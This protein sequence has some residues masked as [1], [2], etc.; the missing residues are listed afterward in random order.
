MS[1]YRV[2]INDCN[3]KLYAASG[4]KQAYGRFHRDSIG[5]KYENEQREYLFKHVHLVRNETNAD[6]GNHL[7]Y[8]YNVDMDIIGPYPNEETAYAA[9][10]MYMETK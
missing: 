2:S 10:L 3:N 1:N 9:F 5:T 8:F 7:H 4:A 6:W